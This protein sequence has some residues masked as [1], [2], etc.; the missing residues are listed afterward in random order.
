MV[1]SYYDTEWL[2]MIVHRSVWLIAII[3]VLTGA[4][5]LKL[6]ITGWGAALFLLGTYIGNFGVPSPE[7]SIHMCQKRKILRILSFGLSPDIEHNLMLGRVFMHSA[8][9]LLGF[10]ALG[11]ISNLFF[12][13]FAFGWILHVCVDLLSSE[14]WM[15]DPASRAISLITIIIFIFASG[16]F[17]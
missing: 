2:S 10:L 12:V 9:I 6:A 7:K 8:I 15:F 11:A 3:L 5:H 13:G 4:I 1:E 14:H 17:F 16:L